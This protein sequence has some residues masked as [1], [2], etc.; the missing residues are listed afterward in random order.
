[1]K[2]VFLALLPIL[3]G[4]Q[5]AHADVSSADDVL[6]KQVGADAAS[7]ITFEPGRATLTSQEISALNDLVAQA[8]MNNDQI[9]EV[10][11]FVWADQVYP[12]TATHKITRQEKKIAQDRIK[13]IKNYLKKDL[14]IR[15]VETFNMAREQRE[16]R[17]LI[18][19]GGSVARDMV[20]NKRTGMSSDEASTASAQNLS[21]W[22]KG[23]PSEALVFIY[24]E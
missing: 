7:Q 15:D 8:R 1:M 21:T 13:N 10:K 23:N 12:D 11:V 5:F 22:T 20:N 24:K 9:D 16:F 6:V 4:V 2:K 18:N 19:A 17:D 14:K 3:F